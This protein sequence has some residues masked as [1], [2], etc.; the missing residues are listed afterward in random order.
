MVDDVLFSGPVAVMLAKAHDSI[1]AAAALPGGTV[2]EP[3]WDGYRLVLRTSSHD[4]ELWSR[5][6]T[7]LTAIFPELVTAAADLPEGLVLD[8]EAVIWSDGRLDFDR[9]Q[10]RMASGPAAAARLARHRPACYVAFDV[11]AVGGI[12]IR[13]SPWRDRRMLLEEVAAGFQPPL[14][15]SPYTDDYP[16]AVEWFGDYPA[17]GIE[18]LVAKGAGSPYRPGVR[19]W[20]KTKSRRSVDAIVGAV[21]GPIEHPEAI[22]AGR[23]T[24]TGE[25]I[26]VGRTTSLT[27]AQTAELAP[28]LDPMPAD[29]HPWPTEIG[30]GHF[31]GGPVT[32]TH[33][34]PNLVV[35][36]AADPAMQA[37]RHRHPLRLQRLRPD[38][39]PADINSTEPH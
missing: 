20:I 34:E 27:T 35:E 6:G 32:I 12:D 16:T 3:K 22:I 21:I 17:V 10:H 26:I 31:G 13:T 14:E 30:S 9:L 24:P 23:Y 19:G 7:N 37:G 1:P 4:A 5:N 11:L 39:R 36:V 18:G 2:W 15:L 28:L 38:L 25:L 33:V 8:G 29:Q